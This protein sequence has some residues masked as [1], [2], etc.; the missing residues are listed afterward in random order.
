ML[1]VLY[2]NLLTLQVINQN[3]KE[4]G[5][6]EGPDQDIEFEEDRITMDIPEEGF[7]T[8]GWTITAL[9]PPMVSSYIFSKPN[10]LRSVVYIYFLRSSRRKW[11]AIRVV[12][13]SHLANS[14]SSGTRTSHQLTFKKE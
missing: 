10:K 7:L 1:P 11:T 2:I 14:K 9:T 3:Y 13:V 8:S 5:A 12:V 4:K 6:I